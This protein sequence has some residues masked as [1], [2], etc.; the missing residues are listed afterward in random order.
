[1]ARIIYLS[2]YFDAFGIY[3]YIAQSDNLPSINKL[4]IFLF[5]EQLTKDYQLV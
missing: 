5:G 4:L 3:C 1:L 2:H